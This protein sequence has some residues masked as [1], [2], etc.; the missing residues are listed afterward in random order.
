MSEQVRGMSPPTILFQ[1]FFKLF[2]PCCFSSENHPPK[3]LL[4]MKSNF[5]RLI[6]TWEKGL[7]SGTTA[8]GKDSIPIP[9]SLI[10]GPYLYT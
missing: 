4:K 8:G 6:A 5:G 1:C 2:P 10:R 7:T 3:L 9:I